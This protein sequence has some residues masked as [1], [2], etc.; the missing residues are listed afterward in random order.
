MLNLH[1]QF[2]TQVLISIS[3]IENSKFCLNT[4]SS[5][6]SK[7]LDSVEDKEESNSGH[8]KCIPRP[9]KASLGKQPRSDS[10]KSPVSDKPRNSSDRV[11]NRQTG[12]ILSEKRRRRLASGARVIIQSKV[13][14]DAIVG[15]S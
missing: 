5:M 6:T 8:S 2:Y 9:I 11:K 15:C 14:D 10:M 4:I 13:P 3:F 12:W 1:G 7:Q